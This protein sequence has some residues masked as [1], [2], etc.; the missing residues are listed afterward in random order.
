MATPDVPRIL[1]QCVVVLL[2][3][4]ML[5][6]GEVIELLPRRFPTPPTFRI[7]VNFRDDLVPLPPPS[8]S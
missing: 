6:R 2:H 7:Q 3:D 8:P 5:R 1:W 4:G